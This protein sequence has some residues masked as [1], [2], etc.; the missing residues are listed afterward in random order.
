MT[1]I[2]DPRHY[3]GVRRPLLDA[4]SLPPWCYTSDAFYRREVDGILARSWH[5]VGR[6]DEIPNPGDYRVFDLCGRSAIVVRGD[7][8]GI[9]LGAR[10]DHRPHWCS[11]SRVIGQE[12]RT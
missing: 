11:S 7:D 10:P 8:G 2:F 6:A 3:E 9:R 5:L 4:A 12:A 1:D